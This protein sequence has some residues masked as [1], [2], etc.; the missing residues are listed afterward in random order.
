M[1]FD[2]ALR[3]PGTATGFDLTI[4]EDPIPAGVLYYRTAAAWAVAEVKYW[5]GSAWVVAQM[6][7]WNGSSWVT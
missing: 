3:S 7:Y 6:A 5:D 4:G 2:V 1:S